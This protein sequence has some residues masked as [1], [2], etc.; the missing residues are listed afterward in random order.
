MEGSLIAELLAW[1]RRQDSRTAKRHQGCPGGRLAPAI[2]HLQDTHRIPILDSV[3]SKTFSRSKEHPQQQ[4]AAII[5]LLVIVALITIL[6]LSLI[7]LVDSENRSSKAFEE[8]IAVRNLSEYPTNLVIA[9]IREATDS[10]VGKRTW[11]SQ[12]GAIRTF[13]TQIDPS[14]GR[15]GLEK[16]YKL[17]SSPEMIEGATFDPTTEIP[18]ENWATLPDQFTDLNEPVL[19]EGLDSPEYVFPIID[20]AALDFGVEGFQVEGAPGTTERQPVPMPT[21]WIYVLEDGSFAVPDE[22]TSGETRTTFSGGS[23]PSLENPIV[24]R[25]AFWTDD[26]SSKVNINTASEGVVWD[27]PR[28]NSHYDAYN[29]ADKQPVQNEFQRFPGHP[30]TT[31][32][33]PALRGWLGDD[34]ATY[35]Q[36]SPF[37]QNGGSF[38]GTQNVDQ[39]TP[40]VELDS[41]RLFATIDEF[42]FD[43]GKISSGNREPSHPAISDE[44]LKATRFFLTAHSRAPDVTLFDTPK[45]NL[46]PIQKEPEHRNA[47]DRLQAF[48]SE[49]R[50]ADTRR[51]YYFQR[52]R[53]H[54]LSDSTAGHGSS[55]SPSEDYAAIPRNQELFSYL[56]GLTERDVP[57]FGQNFRSK[58]PDDRDQILTQI[59]DYCRSGLNTMAYG[60]P[61]E[62]SAEGYVYSPPRTPGAQSGPLG[63]G[64]IIPLQIDDSR[65]FGRSITITEA[66]LVLHPVAHEEDPDL[67][68]RYPGK[69]GNHPLYRATE[70]KAFLMMEFFCASPGLPSWSPYLNITVKGMEKWSVA[71]RSLQLPAESTLVTHSPIGELPILNRVGKGHSCAHMNLLQ[72]FFFMDEDDPPNNRR[73]KI[74]DM[75]SF[76]PIRGYPWRSTGPVLAPTDVET[77]E[78]SGGPIEIE[79]SSAADSDVSQTIRMDFPATTIPLPYVWSHFSNFDGSGKPTRDPE[80][81]ETSLR[82]RIRRSGSNHWHE[83][84]IRPGDTVRSMEAASAMK[85]GGDSLP[86]GDLRFFAARK[87]V[88]ASWFTKGGAEG[89]YDDETR[90]FAHGLRNGDFWQYWGHFCSEERRDSGLDAINGDRH[91]NVRLRNPYFRSSS[92]KVGGSLL[93]GTSGYSGPEKKKLYRDAHPVVARGLTEA[94]RR[95]GRPGDWDQGFGN[96]EDGA[97]INK[98]DES[99]ASKKYWNWGGNYHSGG[100]FRRGNFDID[101]DGNNH[102]PNRQIASAVQFGSLPTGIYSMRP[103]ETLLFCPN[104]AGRV[105]DAGSEPQAEDHIGFSFPRDHLLLD[106]FWMPVT[107]PYAISE[108]FSTAGKVNMNYEILPFSY[109]HRRTAILSALESVSVIAI[110]EI[111]LARHPYGC[112]KGGRDQAHRLEVRYGVSTDEE[113]GTLRGFEK[114]FAS[115]DV[116]RSPS[117]ICEIYLVPE[118][119]ESRNPP[120]PAATPRE[121]ESMQD[122]WNEFRAT[123]DNAREMPYNQLYP[124]LTTQSNVY[125][126]HYR[127]Q[128][129]TKARGTQPDVWDRE[130]DSVASEFRGS[131]LVERYIDPNDPEIPDFADPATKDKPQSL[132]PHYRFRIIQKRRF[133]K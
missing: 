85:E 73:P 19:V 82:E 99:N 65:G 51:P 16:I 94:L 120:A 95:D 77:A 24:G 17:Y 55:Q 44:F 45:I 6:L 129:L 79:I 72:P 128:A 87:E 30:A 105:T 11:A 115:G 28:A 70:F 108:P 22:T 49:L 92:W 62:A 48:C 37:V 54:D 116:F 103:W 13:G 130:L 41:D 122:W 97:F 112:I 67:D 117:E 7:V 4:G 47:I 3:H 86:G 126:I 107:Q 38:G 90:R 57:G 2:C 63:E 59:V 100:Y 1:K 127:V 14:T 5:L 10:K 133:A 106:L 75:E 35:Y 29:F 96:T 104:P 88:P 58:Y 61:T 76:D 20:P 56:Q 80:Q 114:R 84:L 71:G 43:A 119:V 46:W 36:L 132:S 34:P 113:T 26:E 125:R 123:G 40:P 74:R 21:R 23:A 78:F 124:R 32:L 31:S 83:F 64:Q 8:S 18:P 68:I 121:Y 15:A 118:P 93:S 98:P 69:Q 102:A 60:L 25:I 81:V 66:A 53:V 101:P 39:N 9:Q 111:A 42:A 131:S 27:M 110:P 12:P 52:S 50:S 109:I 33:S 91:G 89:D